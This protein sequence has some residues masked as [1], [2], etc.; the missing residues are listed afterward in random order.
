MTVFP[1]FA[2][3]AF[4]LDADWSARP[5]REELDEVASRIRGALD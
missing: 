5:P 4:K 3:D 1:R 2:G